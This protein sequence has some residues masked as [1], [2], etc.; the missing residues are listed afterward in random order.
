MSVGAKVM[1]D[2]QQ[3]S[4][5]LSKKIAN[6][7]GIYL[8]MFSLHL[9]HWGTVVY[10]YAKLFKYSQDPNLGIHTCTNWPIFP[11]IYIYLFLYLMY[12]C[13]F[14]IFKYLTF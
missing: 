13:M 4:T 1:M 7:L 11:A 9:Q 12:A 3:N 8:S 10:Y 14:N 2:L 5:R 6:D